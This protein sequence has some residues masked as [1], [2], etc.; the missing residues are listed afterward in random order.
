MV[1]DIDVM[2]AVLVILTPWSLKKGLFWL[3]TVLTVTPPV[4]VTA[5]FTV[6]ASVVVRVSVP[7]VPVMVTVALPVVAVLDA[8]KDRTLVAVAG[9][10]LNAAL[11]P[12]G[13]PLALNVTLPVNPPDGV[14]VIVLVPADPPC[15]IETLAG[16]GNSE[17]FGVLLITVSVID[18][19]W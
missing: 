3:I 4:P 5:V 2:A 12:V 10:V 1:R 13:N 11:T 17:K 8:V 18:V 14:T 19:V 15:V 6:R 7:L 16:L 9:F